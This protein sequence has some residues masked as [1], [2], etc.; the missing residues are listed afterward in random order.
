MFMSKVGDVFIV[1]AINS[2]FNH[3]IL[4]DTTE[5]KQAKDAILSKTFINKNTIIFEGLHLFI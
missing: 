4:K 2:A 3:I 1:V 5:T